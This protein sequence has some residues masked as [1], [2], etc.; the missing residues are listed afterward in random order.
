[1]TEN[2]FRQLHVKRHQNC[3]PDDCVK[4]DNL[5]ADE[6]NVSRPVF[7]KIS[8]VIGTVAER[9]YI[10]CQRVDPDINNVFRV[11]VNGNA[12]AE[13]C[14]GDTGV[15]KTG[16][17]EIVYHLVHARLRLDKLGVILIILNKAVGVF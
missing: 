16:L 7:F 4:A 17:Y 13:G 6:V 5:F 1:M 8:L 12:P 14:A 3:G 10:V 2:F 9:C 15:F 11:E